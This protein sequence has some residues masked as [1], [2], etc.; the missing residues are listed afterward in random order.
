MSYE[1]LLEKISELPDSYY[2][3]LGD[4]V[5][6]LAKEARKKREEKLEKA[7]KDTMADIAAGRYTTDIKAHLKE[8]GCV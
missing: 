3:K 5:E 8:F 7:I 4:Y 1:T 6:S 2:K